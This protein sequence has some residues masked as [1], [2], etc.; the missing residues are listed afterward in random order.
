MFYNG[1]KLQ[2]QAYR[3]KIQFVECFYIHPY[4]LYRL[5][6]IH[7]F[8]SLQMKY[9]ILKLILII[10]YL[11]HLILHHFCI[12]PVRTRAPIFKCLQNL[13]TVSIFLFY[14]SLITQRLYYNSPHISFQAHRYS[15]FQG[16]EPS[17][18]FQGEVRIRPRKL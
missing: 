12:S 17:S 11:K 3:L 10:E 8:L 4:S 2:I 13:N 15:S 6:T 9:L 16:T 14:F 18:V 1:R 7:D 5:H